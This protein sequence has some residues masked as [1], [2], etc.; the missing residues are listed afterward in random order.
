MQVPFDILIQHIFTFKGY[1]ERYSERHTCIESWKHLA[2]TEHVLEVS[3]GDLQECVSRHSDRAPSELCWGLARSQLVAMGFPGVCLCFLGCVPRTTKVGS[4]LTFLCSARLYFLPP[5]LTPP[6]W[7]RKTEA[8]ARRLS[9]A[10]DELI[11]GSRLY[12]LQP[13]VCK[14]VHFPFDFGIWAWMKPKGHQKLQEKLLNFSDG[15]VKISKCSLA[16]SSNADS[17][18]FD[19]WCF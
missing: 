13:R 3:I 18:G 12:N 14:S 17:P 1:F 8:D 7:E 15:W 4:S 19:A 2:S 9:S 6:W 10:E 5:P 11:S 16:P